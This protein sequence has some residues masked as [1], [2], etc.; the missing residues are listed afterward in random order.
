M[1]KSLNFIDMTIG[2]ETSGREVNKMFIHFAH[3]HNSPVQCS[4]MGPSAVTRLAR[5]LEACK[6][7]CE[8]TTCDRDTETANG[9]TVTW[10]DS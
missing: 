2:F 3:V 10:R 4:I 1:E 9:Y 7:S 6:C 5:T 8:A